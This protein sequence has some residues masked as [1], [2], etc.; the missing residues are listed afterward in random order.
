MDT[1][2]LSV[3]TGV[4]NIG[5]LT[6]FDRMIRSVLSQS[7]SEFEWIICDD[8]STDGT[9]ER[10]ETI[11]ATDNRIRLL[12]SPVNEGLASALNR[13][14]AICRAA[15]IARQDADDLSAPE[16]FALQVLFLQEHPEADFVGSNVILY[17]ETG[18]WGKRI[19]PIKPEKQD[20]LFSMPFVHGALMFRTTAL[21][22]AGNYRVARET[23]RAEDCDLLMR[24][25]A[26]GMV[27]RNLEQSLYWFL[28]DKAAKRRRK[29]CYRIDEFKIRCRGFRA[30]G[31]WPRG[32]PYALK[33]LL[34]GLI[35]SG[36]LDQ[37]KTVAGKQTL[38]PSGE[39][40]KVD[41]P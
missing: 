13:C 15:L 25:Y 39:T 33:P 30:L 31:L 36:L 16:R 41:L 14:I 27:G 5:K 9:W 23:R 10:L 37:L 4:Y 8:G 7:F 28:E 17:D 22:M 18:A 1:P 19:F 29:Y 38:L 26:E 20:F 32:I 2:K 35:P 6:I 12:K 3:I 40:E 11:A 24:M 34:V 21:Q